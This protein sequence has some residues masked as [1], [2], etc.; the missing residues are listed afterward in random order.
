MLAGEGEYEERASV[1]HFYVD[2]LEATAAKC[3]LQ[4]FAVRDGGVLVLNHSS[5]E[6]TGMRMCSSRLHQA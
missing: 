2:S 1:H 6:E 3:N 4:T 5:S